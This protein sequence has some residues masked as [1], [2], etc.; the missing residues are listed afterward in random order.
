MKKNT[1]FFTGFPG[2]IATRIIKKLL[3]QNPNAM[4]EL[5]VHPSQLE[6]AG[7]E[8]GRLEQSGYGTED[9]FSIIPGDITLENLGLN[10]ATLKRLKESVHDVFHL[11][12]IYDLAV[13]KEIAYQVNVIGTNHVNDFVLQLNHLRRYVYFSTAYVSGNRTGKILETELDCGQTFKNFYESTK[14]EAEVL[15]QQIRD[16]V[17]TTIIRPGIVMGDSITGETVKFDGPYFIMRF[18]DKFAK[19]PIPYVGKG[20]VPFNVVPVDYVVEATCYLAQHPAGEN[21]VYH[22]TDPRPY[23]AK[24]AYRMI[25]EALI[26]KKPSFTL[27]LTLVHGLLSIPAFRRWVMVEKESIEYFRL[28][29]DYDCTQTLK[30]LEG[31][32]IACP[33]F[34][35]YYRVAVHFYKQHRLDPEKMILVDQARNKNSVGARSGYRGHHW[36]TGRESVRQKSQ[37]L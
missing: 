18:L 37:S 15:T 31:S 30:D 29:A 24:D 10:P 16:Q 2:F 25:C 22:L 12:A 21:K 5:L 11:A 14:F 26:G 8:I 28:K 33:D 13:P 4:F 27:P 35:D 7:Q 9:Q 36:A 3:E 17:P 19:W 32:G 20:E 34:K 6:N 23:L 1:Y